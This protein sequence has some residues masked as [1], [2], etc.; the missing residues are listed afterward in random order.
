VGACE[1]LI[2]AVF[3]LSAIFVALISREATHSLHL[4]SSGSPDGFTLA[5][6]K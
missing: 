5:L 6:L 4:L 2:W 3:W 1:I